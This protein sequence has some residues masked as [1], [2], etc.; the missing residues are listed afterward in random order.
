MD[1]KDYS[2]YG[3]ENTDVK[4]VIDT[5][6]FT[7]QSKR[8]GR[9]LCSDC[10]KL[11]NAATFSSRKGQAF[12]LKTSEGSYISSKS[13]LI[14]PTKTPRKVKAAKPT[15][16]KVHLENKNDNDEDDDDFEVVT[17]SAEITLPNIQLPQES[18]S[19]LN[20]WALAYMAKN[21]IPTVTLRDKTTIQA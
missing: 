20:L 3:L 6:P 16:V 17:F 8:N 15:P 12:I 7:P 21:R 14:T 1:I 19:K 5:E 18:D 10:F 2:L 9:L 13:K 11:L 4:R